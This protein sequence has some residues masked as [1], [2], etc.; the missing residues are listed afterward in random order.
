M[1]VHVDTDT[2]SVI[3][4][5]DIRSLRHMDRSILSPPG[6]SELIGGLGMT[7]I[8]LGQFLTFSYIS[9]QTS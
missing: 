1:T 5:L 2:D 9:F 7:S 3:M 6:A 4:V 8:G